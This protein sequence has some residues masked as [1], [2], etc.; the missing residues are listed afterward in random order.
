[1][2]FENQKVEKINSRFVEK[3]TSRFNDCF[4]SGEIPKTGYE[5]KKYKWFSTDIPTK[6]FPTPHNDEVLYEFNNHGYR[7]DDFQKKFIN[8]MTVGCS[9]AFG[10][11]IPA[12]KRFGRIFCDLLEENV[13]D[14]N[15]AW[16]GTSGNYVARIISSCIPFLKPDI[17]LVNFPHMSRREFFDAQGEVFAHR[18][19]IEINPDK[20]GDLQEAHI[21]LVSLY[22]DMYQFLM[23]YR[24]I[25]SIAKIHNVKWM[26]SIQRGDQDVYK[27]IHNLIDESCLV[28]SLNKIDVARDGGHPGVE[29]HANHARNYFDVYRRKYATK[30][31]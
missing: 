31:S 1:M 23:N 6:N 12:N 19:R 8:V 15:F 21:S 27:M 20:S 16:P 9:F 24:L 4:L 3:I 14:W 26:Y 25:E 22:Q 28:D 11:G 17:L 29:S 13:C 10:N 5:N 18:L 30:S 2:L 7:S